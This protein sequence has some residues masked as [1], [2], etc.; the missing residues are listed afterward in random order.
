MDINVNNHIIGEDFGG[1]VSCEYNTWQVERIYDIILHHYGRS[2]ERMFN[3][4]VGACD[5]TFHDTISAYMNAYR[6]VGMYIEPIPDAFKALSKFVSTELHP[7]CIIENVAVSDAPRTDTMCYIPWDIIHKNNLPEPI[8]G[9]GSFVPPKNGFESD[10]ETK[11]LLDTYGELIEIPVV[12]VDSLLEKHG[13]VSI[14][15]CTIDTEGFD[16]EVFKG[17]NVEKYLPKVI[18]FELFNNELD[19]LIELFDRLIAVGYILTN[20]EGCDIMA[21]H[22]SEIEK[23]KKNR[24][25]SEVIKLGKCIEG[26]GYRIDINGNY[27][28]VPENIEDGDRFDKDLPIINEVPLKSKTTIVTG[29]WDLKRDTLSDSFKRPFKHYLDRFAELLETDSPM[30]IFIEKK[31]ESFI[32]E[33]RDPENT[34]VIIK[35]VDDFKTWF[36]FYDKV[37]AIRSN[38]DWYNKASW[39]AESTQ[40]GLELYNPMVMSKMFMLNDACIS[41]PFNTDYFLWVDG[42]I[43]NTV[44]QGYFTHDKV[45]NKIHR[46]LQKFLFVCFPYENYEIHGFDHESLRQY[47]NV[48][49]T[50]RVARAGVFGGH[51]KYISKVNELYYAYLKSTLEENQMGTEE[52]IFTILT[53]KHEDLIDRTMI[54]DDGLFDCFF[55]N[56]KNDTVELITTRKTRPV[57]ELK[58]YLYV[59]T[60]NSPEQFLKLC[61]NW[62]ETEWFD[63]CTKVVLNNSTDLST[64]EDY[65]AIFDLYGFEHHKKDNIGICGGRQWVAEHFDKTDGDYYIFLE[66]DMYI[67]TSFQGLCKSGFTTYVPDLFYKTHMIME[68]HGFNFLKFC[69]SEFFG[70]NKTQW[71]WY[72][73]PQDV[74]ERYW[75]EKKHL[76]ASGLDPN[77]PLV[78]YNNI[79]NFDGLA[80]ADGEIFYCNWPQL[81][82]REGNVK[83][84]LTEKWQHPFEQTWMSYMYQQTVAGELY[85]AILLATPCYH[86]RFVYYEASERR[87]N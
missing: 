4:S 64:T 86:D 12:T 36:E 79:Y 50:T 71:A 6:W 26:N 20:Q 43:T 31:Y 15:F 38:P 1:R 30:I 33:R 2:G 37:Q 67:H 19:K 61:E 9:M 40:A 44:H 56:L 27:V 25:W 45:I 54:R 62:S 29:I 60:Y 17:F 39:L 87:E 23:F 5:G 55:E 47:C 14:D 16:Y 81:V 59:I 21:F 10:P 72:N 76:P 68:K 75:P 46:Y 70:D 57:D 78:K 52:S 65:E 35:E 24:R 13:I 32:W 3:L 80:Y 48:D 82:S 83:M 63:K 42:G 11:N 73:V 7:D 58:T 74:R 51:K 41:N 69:F 49:K 8:I 34:S 84:F 77:A 22:S 85:P 18:K 53:Y 28:D 66:D